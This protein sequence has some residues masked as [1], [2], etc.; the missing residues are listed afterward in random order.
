MKDKP[1]LSELLL[2]SA[3]VVALAL[4][5]N[6]FNILMTSAFTLTLIMVLA[7]AIIAFAVFVWREQPRDEREALYGLKVGRISY[8]TSGAVLVVAIIVQAFQHM[9]DLW[10]ALAL[11]VMVV[12]KLVVSAWF[13]QK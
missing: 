2:G 5:I 3:I 9:L 12:T 13:R 11:G 4:L 10:L 8:F 6:P 1:Q 7:V